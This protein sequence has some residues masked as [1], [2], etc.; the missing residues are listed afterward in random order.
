MRAAVLRGFRPTT[1]T[2]RRRNPNGK[3]SD[4]DFMLLEAYQSYEDEI[5][6]KTGLP[7]WL[8]RTSG[9]AVSFQV[10]EGID[11]AEAM[12][13]RFDKAARGPKGDKEPAPGSYRYVVARGLDGGPAPEGGLVREAMLIA[14]EEEMRTARPVLE[15]SDIV[16]ER[17]RPPGG[18]DTSQYG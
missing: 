2:H 15:G 8:T 13:E 4:L 1:L 18:Y 10:E 7:I 3:W 5:G 14:R 6:N 9:A 17:K 16:V 11:E 12:L